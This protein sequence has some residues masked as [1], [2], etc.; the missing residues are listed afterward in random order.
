MICRIR[1]FHSA[2]AALSTVKTMKGFEVAPV[3]PCSMAYVNSDT[4][5]ESFQNSVG[6]VETVWCNGLLYVGI[7][8]P[9]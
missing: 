8:P 4:E 6:V 7:L 1:S 2:S 9:V 5:Q 3:A